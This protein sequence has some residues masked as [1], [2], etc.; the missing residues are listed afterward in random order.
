MHHDGVIV[1]RLGGDA[2]MVDR[3][4]GPNTVRHLRIVD[5]VEREQNVVRSEGLAAKP[6]HVVSKMKRDRLAVGPDVPFLG[7]TRLGQSGDWIKPQQAL[8]QLT[9]E[10]ARA[11]IG[12]QNWIEG[13]RIAANN[14]VEN[15]T[16]CVVVPGA[17]DAASRK[18]RERRKR[19][20]A[21]DYR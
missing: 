9:C 16:L 10:R 3:N 21:R 8:E 6:F 19:N 11:G 14:G 12:D 15:L 20:R 13:A 18:N 17:T 1:G 5:D 4:R 2:L 7:Q